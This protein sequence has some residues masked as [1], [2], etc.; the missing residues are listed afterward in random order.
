M[1]RLNL[2]ELR[3]QYQNETPVVDVNVYGLQLQK[4]KEVPEEFRV[5]DTANDSNYE[6]SEVLQQEKQPILTLTPE[7]PQ[8]KVLTNEIRQVLYPINRGYQTPNLETITSNYSH[9]YDHSSPLERNMR[10]GGNAITLSALRNGQGYYY[11]P[12][13]RYNI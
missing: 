7:V 3:E 10:S 5:M 11:G 12:R 4:V 2:E 1:I 6:N 13:R 9:M 8:P